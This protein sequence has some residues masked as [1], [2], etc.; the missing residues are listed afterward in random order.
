M[1][2]NR[3]HQ[4]KQ[5][6]T[7]FVKQQLSAIEKPP[8]TVDVSGGCPA[9]P[10]KLHLCHGQ[11]HLP[12][13]SVTSSFSSSFQMELYPFSKFLPLSYVSISEEDKSPFPS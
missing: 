4:S 11:Q 5:E 12:Q 3:Y 10:L 7:D 6:N 13:I 9:E 8:E 2:Q 1:L